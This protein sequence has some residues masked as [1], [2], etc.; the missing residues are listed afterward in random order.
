MVNKEFKKWCDIAVSLIRFPPDRERVAKELENHMLDH[1]EALIEKGCAPDD[2]CKQTLEA[3]GRATE[4]AWDLG[5]I[6]RPFWGWFFRITRRI[7][8]ILLAVTLVSLCFFEPNTRYRQPKYDGFNP[9]TDTYLSDETGV[10][11]RVMY[12]EPQK[13]AKLKGY[14]WTLTKAVW[15]HTDFTAP[16]E[17]NTDV[18]YFQIEITNPIPWAEKPEILKQLW[19]RD[20]T[21]KIYYPM[22]SGN[23]GRHLMGGI[24]HTAPFTYLLDMEIRGFSPEDAQWIEIFYNRDGEEVSFRVLLP[25]GAAK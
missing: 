13:E 12:W 21:G 22:Y 25:G 9:Y 4:I 18:F 11:E 2:A 7:L 20:S 5:Q 6:H 14:T 15:T 1:Y 17:E 10:T 23:P 16:E 19:A 24:Y 8:L 3:M